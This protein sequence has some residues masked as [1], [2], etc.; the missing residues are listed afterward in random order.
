MSTP[1]SNHEIDACGSGSE[2]LV[3]ESQ[4][5]AVDAT[6]HRRDNAQPTSLVTMI[7]S[8]MSPA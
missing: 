1:N 4:Y 2:T 7:M 5:I 3:D 8:W 6:E